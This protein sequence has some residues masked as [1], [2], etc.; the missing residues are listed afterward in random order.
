MAQKRDTYVFLL[1]GGTG[2]LAKRLVLPALFELTQQTETKKRFVVL[3][4]ARSEYSDADY[5]ADAVAGMHTLAGVK[6]GA[7]QKWAN[8]H[9][10]YA[11]LGD[12][13]VSDYVR[14][15]ERA[16][17]LADEHGLAPNLL[18]YLALPP[19]VFDDT[20]V[21]MDEAGL[22]CPDDGWSRLVVEKPFGHDLESAQQ[23]NALVHRFFDEKDVY[24]IDHFL[25]K[26]TVQNLLVFRFGNAIF[27]RLWNR[28]HIARVEIQVPERL[29]VGTRAGFYDEAGALRDMV[30]NHLTQL[31]TLVAMEAPVA[32]DG[33][34]IRA[35]KVK[36]LRSIYPIDPASVVFG[37][38]TEG[39][40]G[41]E[42]IPAY[43]DAKGV[44]KGSNTDTYVAL[45]LEIGNWRWQGVPFVM[46][47][48]K[49][50]PRKLTRIRIVFRRAP[51][52]LFRDFDR[53][54]LSA[55]VLTITLSPDEGFSLFFDVKRPGNGF[56]V[57]TR[58]LEFD[59][60]DAFGPKPTAYRTLLEDVARGDRTLFVDAEEVEASWALYDPILKADLK[61]HPYPAGTWG[62]DAARRLLHEN[63]YED[64]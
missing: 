45:K 44:E 23:L 63:A 27:E 59:Y 9:L 56:P 15:K 26:E 49:A 52:S 42:K 38:Y 34:A 8:E 40:I 20:I 30:Q 55:N 50:L 54:A 62:P 19:A 33:D 60:A 22:C 5:R 29:T 43:R 37:Q 57:E 36:V 17:A 53:C 4:V 12:Q 10:F 2:D 18:H 48:G 11:S 46:M 24:R 31:L 7:A 47:T 6:K 21:K 16:A 41:G 39:E 13:Q 32:P 61:V 58:K 35:E 51:V 14:V 3:A 28:D 64:D 25:G 1:Y